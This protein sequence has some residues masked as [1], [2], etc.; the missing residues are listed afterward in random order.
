MPAP[1]AGIQRYRRQAIGLWNI[2]CDAASADDIV[3][4]AAIEALIDLNRLGA[5]QEVVAARP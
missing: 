1:I 5:D 3:A 4:Q 2:S